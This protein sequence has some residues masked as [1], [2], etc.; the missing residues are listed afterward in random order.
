LPHQQ[1]KFTRSRNTFYS[2]RVPKTPASSIISVD[3]LISSQVFQPP[4]NGVVKAVVTS[5]EKLRVKALSASSEAVLDLILVPV[6]S[7]LTKHSIHPSVDKER[8][9]AVL[10][11]IHK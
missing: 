6:V 3:L 10:P 7:T 5:S 4:G 2:I 8:L 1:S 9:K 11:F